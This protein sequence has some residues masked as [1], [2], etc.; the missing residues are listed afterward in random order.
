MEMETDTNID[1]KF[2]KTMFQTDNL[3]IICF[4]L[5]NPGHISIPNISD[6]ESNTFFDINFFDTESDTIKKMCDTTQHLQFFGCF[7]NG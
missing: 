4:L 5:L 2:H 3:L 7:I 6:T 1:A